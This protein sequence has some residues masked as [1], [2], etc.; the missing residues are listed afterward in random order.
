M[1]KVKVSLS[2][3]QDCGNAIR[4]GVGAETPS[5]IPVKD[6]PSRIRSIP[7]GWYGVVKDRSVS[8]TSLTRI[9]ALNLH[10]ELPIQSK[11][12][13]CVVADDGTV[14]YYLHPTDSRYK[15]NGELAKL[16]GTDGQVMVEI[17]AHWAKLYLETDS[18]TG[19]VME[20][21]LISEFKLP[22]FTFVP[23]GY[24]SAFEAA[25]DRTNLKL[26]SVVNTTAQYR[27]GNNTSGWDGTYRSL[28]GK[29]VTS[30]S[31]TNF[32][33]YASNR[34]ARWTCHDEG[35]YETVCN[36]YI[37]EYAS[38]NIQA[39]FTSTLD[40]NGYR[41]GGLGP[42]VSSMPDWNGYNGYNPVVPCGATLTLGN[43][44]GVVSTAVIGSAG[45]SV[46]NAPVPSYRGI[47]NLFGHVW[48]HTDG[49]LIS[50]AASGTSDVYR[51]YDITKYSDTITSDYVKVGEE[52]RSS[53]YTKNVIFPCL[54]ASEVGGDS[55]T[56]WC[57][58]HYTNIP[59]S[60][61]AVRACLWGGN[62]LYGAD[63]GFA[64]AYS[65]TA[66]SHATTAVSSRLCYH[67][68]VS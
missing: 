28:L 52:A 61:S 25:L 35:M 7:Q 50:I 4:E 67:P 44:T 19:H 9:G 30:V 68:V 40:A 63:D 45:T 31:L 49:I 15:E 56:N 16:D 17:P 14:V 62:A 13:R 12:R 20:Y 36:L 10:R 51:C 38:T 66:P 32:R 24:Y 42:G 55:S 8:N 11:M 22:G 6:L 46:Y 29:P 43:A 21:R 64:C 2:I 39:T 27:G 41:Q 65:T 5:E 59:S 37:I 60:G 47:E 57:D 33:T 26:A 1:T 23:K 53:G 48:K 34:G 3:L 58:Y 18:T 54:I